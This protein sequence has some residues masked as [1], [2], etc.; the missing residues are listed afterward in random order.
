MAELEVGSVIGSSQTGRA[1]VVEGDLFLWSTFQIIGDK[2]FS[3]SRS[4]LVPRNI[5]FRLDLYFKC[6]GFG[7]L[8]STSRCHSVYLGVLADKL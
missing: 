6:V 8:S 1:D 4:V 3:L 2:R 7:R 5:G